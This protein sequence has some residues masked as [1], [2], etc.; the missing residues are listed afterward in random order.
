[1]KQ[2]IT[3]LMNRRNANS[4]VW[5]LILA[6]A[7]IGCSQNKEVVEMWR[8]GEGNPYP[9]TVTQEGENTVYNFGDM[10][11]PSDKMTLQKEKKRDKKAFKIIPPLG[12][13]S[14]IEDFDFNSDG[15]RV[16][17]VGMDQKVVMW[18]LT[19]DREIFSSY[20]HSDDI[21]SVDFSPDDSKVITSSRDKTICVWDANDGTL[22]QT[23]RGHIDIVGDVYFFHNDNNKAFSIVRDRGYSEVFVWDL[24][25]GSR[26]CE[27]SGNE[28]VLSANDCVLFVANSEDDM[29]TSYSMI[30]GYKLKDYTGIPDIDIEFPPSKS[31]IYTLNIDASQQ[32]IIAS[33]GSGVTVVWNISST[34]PIL[35]IDAHKSR[36]F[37]SE[38]SPKSEFIFTAGDIEGTVKLWDAKSGQLLFQRQEKDLS[39]VRSAIFSS[40]GKYVA[41]IISGGLRIINLETF[42]VVVNVDTYMYYNYKM[43]L[44]ND[45]NILAIVVSDKLCFFDFGT[46]RKTKELSSHVKKPGLHSLGFLHEEPIMDQHIVGENYIFS[47][48]HPEVIH[49]FE[50]NLVHASPNGK[51][52]W[53]IRNKK[54]LLEVELSSLTVKNK[55][56]MPGLASED[57]NTELQDLKCSDKYLFLEYNDSI[58]IHERA[59]YKPISKFSGRNLALSSDPEIIGFTTDYITDPYIEDWAKNSLLIRRINSDDTIFYRKT[60]NCFTTLKFSSDLKYVCSLTMSGYYNSDAYIF[61]IE[62]KVPIDTLKDDTGYAEFAKNQNFIIHP[63]RDY[64]GNSSPSLQVRDVNTRQNVSELRGARVKFASG[65]KFFTTNSG[66]AIDIYSSDSL[67]IV[68]SLYSD[69]PLGD[70]LLFN[71]NSKKLVSTGTNRNLI[72]WDTRKQCEIYSI[73]ILE[74]NN[75]LIQIPNS[76]YYMSSPDAL[77]YLCFSDYKGVHCADEKFDKKYNKP[78]IVLKE[79]ERYFK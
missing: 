16:V 35:K 15:T 46:G 73:M 3:E 57:P 75:W 52:G 63:K 49:F 55:L 42:E 60:N 74:K 59:T 26:L 69:V 19:R 36:I 4:S 64:W 20:G 32:R 56:Q 14:Y 79:I 25:T 18:D 78:K 10:V 13:S 61:D 7:M 76:P 23:L 43:S 71:D 12:H 2:T 53:I 27:F 65:G 1:M 66:K 31:Q 30:T 21:L 29:I 24:K 17:T 33:G 62:N 8:D 70:V 6:F 28:A 54:E 77:S 34:E 5:T 67:T 9:V 48:D 51:E 45:P 50:D 41:Y 37:V 40:D 47:I 44:T 58:F 38:F 72:V 68:S 39:T 11:L 22:L